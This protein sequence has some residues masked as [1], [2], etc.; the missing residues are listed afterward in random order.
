MLP[1]DVG[2]RESLPDKV[3][4]SVKAVTFGLATRILGDQLQGSV[5]GVDFGGGPKDRGGAC[6]RVVIDIDQCATHGV[7]PS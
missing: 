2:F 5:D 6:K 7:T 4:Q 1:P 3:E